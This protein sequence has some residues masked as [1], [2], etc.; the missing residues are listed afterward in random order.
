[1]NSPRA[2][3]RDSIPAMIAAV[4]ERFGQRPALVDGDT[5]YS[6][7]ELVEQSRRFGA[8]LVASGTAPGD[9][10]PLRSFHF[11]L[12]VGAGPG[13]LP[14]NGLAAAGPCRLLGSMKG[15]QR[16]VLDFKLIVI[17]AVYE[18]AGYS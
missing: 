17:V 7:E 8:A 16:A 15:G 10:A 2:R 9:R 1:M 5:R 6:Y 14:P 18:C 4:V 13:I 11:R 3:G 12:G